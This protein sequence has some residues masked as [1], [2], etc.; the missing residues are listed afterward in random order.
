M[1]AALSA[2]AILRVIAS[3]VAAER[4]ALGSGRAWDAAGWTAGTALGPTGLALDSL[5]LV[6]SADAVSRFFRLHETGSDAQLRTEPTLGG[7]TRI[8]AGGLAGAAGGGL[9]FATSGTTGLPKLCRQPFAVLHDEAQFWARRLPGRR[10]VLQTVGAHHIY[11]FLFTALLP[12]VI[13]CPVLDTRLMSAASLH[14]ALQPGDLLVGVPGGLAALL[15]AVPGQTPGQIPGQIPWPADLVAVSATSPLPAPLHTALRVH[16]A[17][18][19]DIYG[20]SETAGIAARHDPAEPFELLPRWRRGAADGEITAV[21]TGAAHALPDHAT[22]HGDRHLRP[23]QRVDGAVQ[24]AGIN[25]FPDQVAAR[26]RGHPLLAD[27]AVI[28]DTSLPEPRLRALIVPA[29]HADAAT[30]VAACDHWSRRR[31]TAPER[32][33]SFE[34]RS[35][36]P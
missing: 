35:S 2:A 33:V 23:A 9:T 34:L 28:L 7:W 31:F 21:A 1:P 11:G 16:A 14:R 24:V 32:P 26:L 6:A 4:A 8:V 15:S 19:V 3:L 22:W 27:C 36:L 5:E 13:G 12:D 18:V 30:I 29:P 10:R 17:E 20:S 25:V